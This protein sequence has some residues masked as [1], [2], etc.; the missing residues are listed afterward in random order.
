MHDNIQHVGKRT[1]VARIEEFIEGKNIR[2]IRRKI[3][4]RYYSQI[5]NIKVQ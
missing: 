4:M 2:H 1:V 5:N 3:T